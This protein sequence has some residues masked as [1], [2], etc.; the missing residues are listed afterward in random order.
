MSEAK[1]SSPFSG[2]VK[3]CF[4]SESI[5]GVDKFVKSPLQISPVAF[6][7]LWVGLKRNEVKRKSD[8]FLGAFSQKVRS[9][10]LRWLFCL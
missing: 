4:R 2:E 9:E 5:Q 10:S 7:S 1:E 3:T 8:R 6:S